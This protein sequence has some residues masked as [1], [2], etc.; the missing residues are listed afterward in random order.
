MHFEAIHALY[1]LG[2]GLAGAINVYIGYS[3]VCGGARGERQATRGRELVRLGSGALLAL[4]GSAV[5]M[6][7][8]SS[9]G[10]TARG[11]ERVIPTDRVQR[12]IPRRQSRDRVLRVGADG[13]FGTERGTPA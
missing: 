11:G 1:R 3:L 12:G 4:F 8:V 9:L 5:L 10:T 7:D 2:I 6:A 13:L